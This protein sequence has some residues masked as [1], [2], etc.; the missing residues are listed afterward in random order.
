MVPYKHYSAEVISGALDGIVTP[1]DADSEDAPCEE[2][3]HRWHHW[4]IANTLRI[5]GYL[6]SIGYQVLGFSEELLKFGASLL[7]KLR[8]SSERWLET[9]LRFI[10]NSGGYLVPA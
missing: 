10:Y 2:T 5:D 9:I 7:Q 8:S 4:L 6:K 3:I 1:D